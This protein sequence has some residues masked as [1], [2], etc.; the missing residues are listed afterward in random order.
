MTS[1][2]RTLLPPALLVAAALCLSACGGAPEAEKTAAADS[3][4][5]P[6]KAT[7]CGFTSTVA[8]APER[9]VT[10]NQ[11]ATEVMLALGLEDRLAGTAY[12]DDS[13]PTKWQKAYDSV[14]VLSKEYP[15]HES[16]LA[17]RPDF[18]YASYISAFDPEVAGSPAELATLDIGSYNSPLGCGD[19]D[20]PAVSFDTVWD[21]IETVAT[22]F[23]VPERADAIKAEQQKALGT[24][25]KQGAGDGVDVFWFDSGDK[26]PL[27]GAGEGGPQLI[28]D[29][30]GATNLFSD[31]KGGWAD[32][33][34][35]RVVKA[36]PDVIVLG[37]ASW[38]SADDKIALLQKDPALKQLEAVRE[39]RF[40]VLPYSETTP[41]VRLADGAQAVADGLDALDLR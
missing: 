13:V 25:A 9:A 36:D 5:H 32:V 2:R 35:E 30:V 22:V 18:V 40:V 14:K 26:T 37:D 11:G 20:L 38:S 41:G 24:L 39:K 33:S 28:L 6:V 34:W 19:N 31:L 29:A 1:S 15:D 21:E 7:S 4:D 17:A 3:A 12:L 23:G 27:A 8:A 10:M 16:L